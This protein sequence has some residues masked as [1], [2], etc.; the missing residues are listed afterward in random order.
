MLLISLR[1][2]GLIHTLLALVN[3]DS[4]STLVVAVRHGLN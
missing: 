4:L 3:T 1:I 2:K